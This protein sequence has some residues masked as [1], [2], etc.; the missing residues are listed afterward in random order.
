MKEKDRESSAM[1]SGQG[2]CFGCG[3]KNPFGLRL[4]FKRDG[5]SVRTEYTPG[6]YYQS[7]PDIIH[8][9]I[10]VTMLDEAMGHAT[11]MNSGMSLSGD[12]CPVNS[13]SSGR[14]TGN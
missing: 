9:G 1:K 12:P 3:K 4:K 7:W 2:L 8:G 13:T 11:L 14:T 6:E 10:I 5:K